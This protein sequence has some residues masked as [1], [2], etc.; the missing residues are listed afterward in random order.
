MPIEQKIRAHLQRLISESATLALGDGESGQVFNES[1]RSQCVGWLVS[2][3]HVVSL[4]CKSPTEPYRLQMTILSNSVNASGYMVNTSVGQAA[5]ILT[6]L[7]YD[8]E[9]GLIASLVTVARAEALDDLL[10][11][12]REY[13]KR[14]NKQGA[15]ILATAVFEDTVRRLARIK[16]IAEAGVSTDRVIS[17]LDRQQF[18]TSILAKRCRVAAGVRNY[19][20]HAQWDDFSLEDVGDVMRLTHQLLTEHLASG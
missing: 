4:I 14:N 6:R 9:N 5:E 15:G 1:H 12:A 3:T 11:Q 2:A 18:I 8:V 17:E 20:L 13:Q 19:A 7:S 10:D 16:E